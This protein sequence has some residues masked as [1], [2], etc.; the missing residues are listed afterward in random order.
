MSC[1]ETFGIAYVYFMFYSF[2]FLSWN[3]I[4]FE[5]EMKKVNAIKSFDYFI[6]ANGF[7]KG[8]NNDG[9]KKMLQIRNF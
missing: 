5:W 4:S 3:F 2:G 6:P 9:P 8:G 1:F 7:T